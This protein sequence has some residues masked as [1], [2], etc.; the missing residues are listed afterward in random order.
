MTP[1]QKELIQLTQF[2]KKRQH[3]MKDI[4]RS[5]I[6]KLESKPTKKTTTL[7]Q[8]IVFLET[9]IERHRRQH[10][11]LSKQI[12]LEQKQK[13]YDKLQYL[14]MMLHKTENL[15]Q[16]YKQQGKLDQEEKKELRHLRRWMETQQKQFSKNGQHP[17]SYTSKGLFHYFRSTIF[18]VKF[19]YNYYQFLMKKMIHQKTPMDVIRGFH[20]S[21]DHGFAF[22]AMWCLLISLG[23]CPQFPRSEY[24]FYDAELKEP[25]DATPTY[26]IT[27]I[28]TDAEY[29]QFLRQTPIKGVNGKSDI[30]L[31]RKNDGRWIFISCKYYVHEHGDYDI[32][33]IYQSIQETNKKYPQLIGENYDIYIFANNKEKASNILQHS[34]VPDSIKN[35]TQINGSFS[36]LGM[37]DLN[38]C[39]ENFTNTTKN[40][41]KEQFEKQF[42]RR[43]SNL[44]TLTLRLD[45]IPIVNNTIAIL[46]TKPTQ[47][48]HKPIQ[49][50]R[51]TQQDCYHQQNFL[52]FFW[53]TIPQFGKS[54]CLGALLLEYSQMHAL[55]RKQGYFNTVV[56]VDRVDLMTK[57]TRDVLGGHEQFADEF[58]VLEVR[59]EDS[60]HEKSIHRY[61][62]TKTKQKIRNK[63]HKSVY[64]NNIVVVLKKD[65]DL[66]YD[67]ENVRW[68]VFDQYDD[69]S[70][71]QFLSFT[72]SPKKIGL[73]MTSSKPVGTPKEC[74]FWIEW[75]LED[76][77]SIQLISK[78]WKQ[79]HRSILSL[80]STKLFLQ[81][82][83]NS[84]GRSVRLPLT[85]ATPQDL[86]R[87]LKNSLDLHVISR[88]LQ[89]KRYNF[90]NLFKIINPASLSQQ[91]RHGILFKEK[92][93]V[94]EL[95]EKIK[96]ILVLISN[97]KQNEQMATTQ[98]WF[99]P[100]TNNYKISENLRRIMETD[101]YFRQ[102]DIVLHK[103]PEKT[104]NPHRHP[105]PL[106]KEDRNLGQL[107]SHYQTRTIS[108][109]KN[110]LIFLLDPKVDM[111]GM[112]LP[113]VDIVFSLND[114]TNNDLSYLMFSKCMTPK[115]GKNSVYFVDFDSKRLFNFMERNFGRN[116]H[117]LAKKLVH[118]LDMDEPQISSS[119]IIQT[120]IMERQDVN[121]IQRQDNFRIKSSE[122]IIVRQKTTPNG[123][124]RAPS[125]LT[126]NQLRQLAITHN[127]PQE[128]FLHLR[129]SHLY[130]FLRSRNIITPRSYTRS[131]T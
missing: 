52:K 95:L 89:P 94:K 24:D 55:L 22:E 5:R 91:Q 13:T 43:Y 74:S 81:K 76:T 42:L 18:P 50:Q 79:P 109:Q 107:I 44:P 53:K 57:Y 65:L 75:K 73:F 117:I 6:E 39:F 100:F 9:Q 128:Q 34:D 119:E 115:Q 27:N 12:Q 124:S 14:Q 120:L 26:F 80:K 15:V 48:E 129:R 118:F 16:K 116:D 131:S 90:N 32:Q 103:E 121:G 68:I 71:G 98:L 112:S 1:L 84:F 35:K 70:E 8:D 106:T 10:E 49:K 78:E 123:R 17:L 40:M 37:N 58:Y 101:A 47:E 46:W 96:E 97:K 29:L 113:N 111:S 3:L 122:A 69:Q 7:Q 33:A 45:Q 28:L 31:R 19:S 60:Q 63:L 54:Y 104:T 82:H 62:R 130:N 77:K 21:S 126:L 85:T 4:L 23:F 92:P 30:T 110:G 64:K 87:C 108:Q 38:V 99:L 41:S 125:S 66:V 83:E 88:F 56:I 25:T 59:K 36:I 105:P 72:Q 102:F 20:T 51:P 67:L 93:K 61:L 86:D 114:E 11:R 2:N 127:V